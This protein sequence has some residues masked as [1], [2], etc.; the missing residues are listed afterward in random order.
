MASISVSVNVASKLLPVP[1][2]LPRLRF[3]WQ[4]SRFSY[5]AAT[6]GVAI[7]CARALRVIDGIGVFSGTL[8]GQTHP[9]C[10][11]DR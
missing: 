3:W 2:E 9:T 11:I 8:G 1:R 10:Q 6:M 5:S 4:Q 7:N